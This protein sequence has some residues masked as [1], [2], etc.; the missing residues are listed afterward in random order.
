MSILCAETV[1]RTRIKCTTHSNLT[2]MFHRLVLVALN[3]DLS[4]FTNQTLM[5][6]PTKLGI[7]VT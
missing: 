3:T 1:Y 6:I 2:V 5:S 4:I 7:V